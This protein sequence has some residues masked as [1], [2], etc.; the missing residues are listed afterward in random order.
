MAFVSLLSTIHSDNTVSVERH[1]RHAEGGRGTVQK[2][3]AIAE[4]NNDMVESTIILWLPPW[5][6]KVVEEGFLLLF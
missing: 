1:S 2:P 3:E 6:C 4:Y 5:H